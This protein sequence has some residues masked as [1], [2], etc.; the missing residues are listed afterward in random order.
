M[1][2]FDN[3]QCDVSLNS[4]LYD[5]FISFLCMNCMAVFPQGKGEITK[6]HSGIERSSDHKNDLSGHQSEIR[7]N[8]TS[9]FPNSGPTDNDIFDGEILLFI[10][11]RANG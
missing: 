8:P 7:W 10:I 3:T 9:E 6:R 4:F 11:N 1:T 2:K 5:I